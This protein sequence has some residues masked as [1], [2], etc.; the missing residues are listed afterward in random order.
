VYRCIVCRCGLVKLPVA[1]L[2]VSRGAR[3]SR[4]R[5]AGLLLL[6]AAGVVTAGSEPASPGP[7]RQHPLLVGYFPQW[8]LYD[9]DQQFTVRKLVENGSAAMLD[10]LNYAQGFVKNGRCSV[11]DANADLNYRFT[12]RTSVDG[13]ADSPASAFRGNFHQLVELKHLY[14]GLKILISLE[15][16]G[17]DFAADAKP[18]ARAAF[19]ASCVNVFLKGNFGPGAS[20]PGL[21]DGIDIDWE[22]PGASGG[23]NFLPLVAEFRR[24]MNAFRPGLQLSVALGTSPDKYGNADIAAI[25][26]LVDLAGLMTYDYNGPWARTTGFIAPLASTE[27]NEGSV[28]ASVAAWE[29]AG[30]PAGK[31][32]LGLPFYA[33]GWL[34]VRAGNHGLGQDGRPYAGDHPYWFIQ[35]IIGSQGAQPATSPPDGRPQ[36]GSGATA[37]R[38]HAAIYRDPVSQEPWLLDGSTF[39]TYEDPVSIRSKA[40]FAQSEH[41][42]GLMVWELSEDT[43]TA[44]LLNAAYDALT[45]PRAAEHTAD[46]SDTKR[47]TR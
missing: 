28:E 39:W 4:F 34:N 23:A 21:F 26:K 13:T 17:A 7:S 45:H 3:P 27:P 6:L 11:A 44:T 31:M 1:S 9:E 19:V 16:R 37:A 24:Q 46:A 43:A 8:G 12:A 41:L 47:T 10:Q 32:L 40:A 42:A 25:G 29:K 2:I 38:P 36:P 22:Y 20:A 33:Y 35:T 30:L 18:E 14:P 5:A 15:G